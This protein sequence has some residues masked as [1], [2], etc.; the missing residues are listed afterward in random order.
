MPSLGAPSSG[1]GEEGGLVGCRAP[2][3]GAG[4]LQAVAG[5]DACVGQ[6]GR[7][8]TAKDPTPGG[9]GAR[10]LYGGKPLLAF[11]T[12]FLSFLLLCNVLLMLS[13]KLPEF[14]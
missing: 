7:V 1:P 4:S 5:G 10:R 12:G 3:Q 9:G 2:G 14:A 6:G 11:V 13:K 8:H